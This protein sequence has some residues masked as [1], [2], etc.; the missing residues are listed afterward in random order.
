MKDL[1]K[2]LNPAQQEAVKNLRGPV[3]ILAGAGS[4]KTKTLTTR[5]A[6]II[7]QGRAHAS[8][9]LA[10]TF[11]NKAAGEMR[12]RVKKL[13]SVKSDRQ[14]FISTF[15][16]LC[17]RILRQEMEHLGRPTTFTILDTDEQLTAIKQA[18]KE[19]NIDSTRYAPGAVLNYISSAKNE[20]I[21]P[22]QYTKLS[23]GSFQQIVA[24]V[25]PRYQELLHQNNSV[26]FDDLLLLTVQLFNQEPK[27]LDRYQ[28]LFKYVMVDEYQDTNA[29]Q[30]QLTRL[31]SDKHH[32]LFVVG[33]DWQCLVPGSLIE[34]QNGK[35]KIENVAKGELVRSASGYGK[36]GYFK[37]LNR[38]KF[39][40]NGEIISIRTA[41][42]CVMTCTPNHLLFSRLGISDSYFVY[43]MYSQNMGYRIGTAKGTRFDGKK[44]DTGLRVRANQERAE[45]MWIIKICDSRA[46]AMY[47]EALFAYKY[48]IP[49]LV[50]H[51]Y[52]N[53]SMQLNQD[54]INMLYQEIDTKSRANQLMTDLGLTFHYPH[55]SPQATTRNDIKRISLNVALFGDKRVT[56]QSPWSA[57][58][59]SSVTTDPKDLMF[60]E[61][62]GYKI[63]AGRADT[64][65]TEIH[66]L[67]YGKIEQVLSRLQENLGDVQI[68]KYA[69]LTDK[70]FSF[71]PASQIHPSMIIP[72]VKNGL[73]TEDR[74]IKVTKKIYS[75]VV[76]DLDVDKVH[77][78]VASGLVV[79]NSIY[80][81]RGANYR[82]IL[83]FNRDYPAAKVIKLEE[84]YRSTQNI[85]DAAGAVIAGNVNRSQKKLWTNQGA[86]EPLSII[87]V[88]TEQYEGAFI[89]EEIDRQRQLHPELTLND[90]VALY[91]TN[92]QSRALEE[93]FLKRGVPYRVVGGVR[94]YDRKEIKDVLAYLRVIANP[95]DEI[96]LQRIINVPARGI[97]EKG[98][99]G[100]REFAAKE[101][102]KLSEILDII[103]VG[104]K[105]KAALTELSKVMSQARSW[106]KNLSG[107][108]DLVINKTGYLTF[109]NDKTIEGETRIENVKE[110]K[111]VVEKYDYLEI[112]LALQTFLEEVSLIQDT[113]SYNADSEAVTLMTLHSAKGLEFDSVFIAGMEENLFPH[114]RSLLNVEELEEE[115]RLCYV[116]ITRA[117]RKVYLL[118]ATQRLIYGK[119]YLGAPSRFLEDIPVELTTTGIDELKPTSA[120]T[121]K[122]LPAIKVKTGDMVEHAHFGVGSVIRVSDDEVVVLFGKLGV[123]RLAK[124]LAP[125]KKLAASKH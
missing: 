39:S 110:L 57:S 101:Q 6:Y 120:A 61:K 87:N 26:D 97:G 28:K 48:G 9:I 64:Y 10:V 109:L 121:D 85:L 47:T 49:M 103:P 50:F 99:E 54:Q 122:P 3:L 112:N 72:I 23:Q 4:G 88:P 60:F 74:V 98:W 65:R 24:R 29:A 123:K 16:S 27:V 15:H 63:R 115:R 104:G 106:K 53:R 69:F 45:R 62:L 111:S 100:L 2:S 114:S 119:Q 43:L 19:L 79:H 105:A 80:S 31:L 38:K 84:N 59:I 83:N 86:G 34:A 5:I 118:H 81:W 124:G 116:G 7:Q 73:V 82:N 125:L 67:D 17:V 107:L 13:L 18:L 68:N 41:A 93:A 113:D 20:M 95:Q 36:T 21:G 1:L 42:G 37:V 76:Y 11:T 55:F 75:G 40:Y 91:R 46:E 33:D 96:S 102:K 35:K 8:E 108:F 58:R 52:G 92:A 70:K 22:E 14:F 94:F 30:Y 25:Y 77:N 78:Y 12:D 51:A 56:Q 90:F 89:I 117:K 71:M 44:H 66:N 32:N